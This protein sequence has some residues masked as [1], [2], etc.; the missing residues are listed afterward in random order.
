MPIIGAGISP[1]GTSPAGIGFYSGLAASPTTILPALTTGIGQTGRLLNPA[2]GDYTFTSDGRVNGEATVPQLVKLALITVYNSACV[3]IGIDF[4][5]TKVKHKG[6]ANTVRTN[7][8]TA[9]SNLVNQNLVQIVSITV[10][11]IPLDAVL[12]VLTWVDLTSSVKYTSPIG[13]PQP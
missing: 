11:D 9:M 6:F 10:Y 8:S 7:I 13:P 1:A 2:T 3:N 12:G 4:T 5:N